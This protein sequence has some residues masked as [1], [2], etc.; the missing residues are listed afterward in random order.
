MKKI[1]ILC[2]FV[3]SACRSINTEEL[4]KSS[5]NIPAQVMYNNEMILSDE[6]N[7]SAF[8]NT[9]FQAVSMAKDRVEK[10]LKQSN[11]EKRKII[12]KYTNNYDKN[13]YI[14][15]DESIISPLNLLHLLGIPA[16]SITSKI[17]LTGTV[18]TLDGVFLKEYISSAEETTY[19]ALYYGYT[20]SN[21]YVVSEAKAF[22]KAY[23]DLLNQINADMNLDDIEKTNV[24]QHKENLKKEETRKKQQ[25]EQAKQRA[26][27]RKQQLISKYGEAVANLIL[28][29]QITLGMSEEAL[30]ESWGKPRDINESV[31]VWGV[32]KQ[33]VYP[34]A[35]VYIEN[36][37]ISSWNK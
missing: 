23:I 8:A 12:V 21:A 36:G 31:G 37:I 19:I 29:Q 30:I 7:V 9:Y 27:K 32:H 5:E 14:P 28:K 22:Q 26:E 16:G 13:T 4:I 25:K 33:Y 34:S 20:E 35:Y 11:N 6:S 1:A 24:K 2:L 10:E 17:T 15:F 18:E 3:L